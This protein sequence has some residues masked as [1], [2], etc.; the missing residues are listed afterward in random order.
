MKTRLV[1]ISYLKTIYFSILNKI[2]L[3]YNAKNILS[4]YNTNNA[5]NIA[6]ISN[7]RAV[8]ILKAVIKRL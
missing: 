8:Y 2:L 7:L 5:L 3:T 4:T 1:E 6:K